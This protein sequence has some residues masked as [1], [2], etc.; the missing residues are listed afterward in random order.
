MTTG[1]NIGD[2]VGRVIIDASGVRTGIN[3]AKNT[4][5]SGF[6]SLGSGMSQFGGAL[7]ALTAPITAFGIKGVMAAG[8]FDD[9][10]RELS[11]RTG[12]VGDDLEKM[13]QA[14]IDAG[15]AT[16]F[17]A[18]DAANS[19]LQLTS[20]GLSAEDA[21]AVLPAV[22]NGAAAAGTDLG[23][24]ADWITDIMAAFGLEAGQAGYVIDALVAA[25]L[26]GSA[27]V[28]DLAM[29]FQNAGGIAALFGMSVDE[30]A[31]ALQ[32]FSENG[33]KGAEAGTQLKSMLTAMMRD[34]PEVQ[35]AW[36]ELGVSMFDAQ[37]NARDLDSV[38]DDL[39]V[40]MADMSQEERIAYIQTLAGS[41]GQAG[42]AA[43]LAAGG[44][45]DMQDSMAGAADAA[46]VAE[47]KM[48]GWRGMLENLSGSLETFQIQVLTPFINDKLIPLGDK[49]AGVVN[50]MTAWAA[51][52]PETANTIVMI[53]AALGVLGPTML[54]AGKIINSTTAILS[55]MGTAIG[56]LTSP[57]GLVIVAIGLL[58]YAWYTN[59]GGFRDAIDRV[60]GSLDKMP[61]SIKGAI[62]A[63]EIFAVA[64]LTL[65]A[66]GISTAT[67]FGALGTAIGFLLSPIGLVLL[68][69]AALGLAWATNFGGM[70]E[71]VNLLRTSLDEKDIPG[72]LKAILWILLAI[73]IGIASWIGAMA[74][75]DV[76]EGLKAWEGVI[77]N[78][79]IILEALPGAIDAWL[80]NQLGINVPEGLSAWQITID[81]IKALVQWVAD[82]AGTLL[83]S[84]H[85]AI[86][87]SLKDFASTV[88]GIVD[89][90]GK[91][92]G[93]TEL[94]PGSGI[95]V[96]N[97]GGLF[98]AS[99]GPVS[100]GQPYIVGEEGPEWFV[101]SQNG[102]VLP[103]GTQPA[104]GGNTIYIT[105][106]VTPD[107][108]RDA[109]TLE[110][111]AAEFGAQLATALNAQG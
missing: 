44:I 7:T 38:I 4:I 6:N 88:S 11:A 51:A 85:I 90:L 30:T 40:A 83:S 5:L 33:I 77:N 97:I 98:R 31:A 104:A 54:I 23:S 89:G 62:L 82:N 111:N 59:F 91:I 45:D 68:A 103:N 26:S 99:G 35:A 10:M 21:L 58:A 8:N 109:A 2:A 43:L 52:N 72:A 108:I 3:E 41:Y 96:N 69:I 19:L 87:Q 84:I 18:T 55:T 76:P 57:I 75:I 12:I 106:E 56:F 13:K 29:G 94:I 28:E 24:T 34:T 63:V 37:G 9:A 16:V 66:L 80:Q 1:I 50:K 22:M 107:M 49:V 102:T 105:V 42:L 39:N 14:A 79:K 93:N 73:P 64:M 48:G 32:I 17:S 67:A 95:S 15:A 100:S 78:V 71:A 46:T 60:R 53:A 86:P 74:G 65:S 25:S 61:A 70:Q 81:S 20:S 47:S 36:A 92:N 27:S 101:P 110:T